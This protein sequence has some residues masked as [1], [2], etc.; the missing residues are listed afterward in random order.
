MSCENDLLTTDNRCIII[1]GMNGK[2]GNNGAAG[3]VFYS[4][5]A[6]YNQRINYLLECAASDDIVV[7][8][9]SMSNFIE[10]AGKLAEQASLVLTDSGLFVG[11]WQI[12]NRRRIVE[13][14]GA[15]HVISVERTV[16]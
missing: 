1:C 2:N 3:K 4:G 6:R 11:T 8:M 14:H 10:Y 13:F 16:Q 7:N 15:G 5:W 12:G 9:A